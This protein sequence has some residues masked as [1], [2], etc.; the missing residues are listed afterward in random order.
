MPCVKSFLACCLATFVVLAA[1]LCAQDADA[2]TA[3]ADKTII[4]SDSL[5][6]PS[7]AE[8]F[9]A[10]EKKLRPQWAQYVRQGTPPASSHRMAIAFLIGGCIAN[11]NLAAQ[12]QDAQ[13]VRNIIKEVLALAK[14]LN[15]AQAVS[16]RSNS[17][18][19]FSSASDWPSVRSEIEAIENEIKLDL[20]E[21]KDEHLAPVISIGQWM[22]GVGVCTE[23]LAKSYA[24]AASQTPSDGAQASPDTKPHEA[25][26]LLRQGSVLD[27]LAA[28]IDDAPPAV[29]ALAEFR[30]M[31]DG[32]VEMTK[33]LTA[34]EISE[35]Q[36]KELSKIVR[37]VATR[38]IGKEEVEP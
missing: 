32:L 7:S 15:V 28:S 21:Q 38:V 4:R 37:D 12:V 3:A 29:R 8:M 30:A 16:V 11:A 26:E 10:F 14:K 22:H 1:P 27:F 36:V 23:V 33:L 25:V 24:A 20:I 2:S 9:A 5:T 18:A 17:I 19:D 6:V 34:P 35:E 31:R 13:A